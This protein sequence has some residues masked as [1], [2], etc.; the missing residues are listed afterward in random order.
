[1]NFYLT[2]YHYIN[3]FIMGA[4][5]K[6]SKRIYLKTFYTRLYLQLPLLRWQKAS[7]Y[8]V[9]CKWIDFG[10]ITASAYQRKKIYLLDQL[11]SS[12]LILELYTPI[13]L[14]FIGNLR[15]RAISSILSSKLTK[16]RTKTGEVGRKIVQSE[17]VLNVGFRERPNHLKIEIW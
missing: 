10:L 7:S 5:Y 14:Q 12:V 4:F 13:K 1:M 9:H 3:T 2:F 6:S 8:A 11:L 17:G 16:L 15:G